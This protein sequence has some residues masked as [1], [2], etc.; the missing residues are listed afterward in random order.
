MKNRILRAAGLAAA[1]AGLLA[2]L[3]GTANA[4]ITPTLGSER[5]TVNGLPSTVSRG[6]TVNLVIWY[7]ET[8][9]YNLLSLAD[10]LALEAAGHRNPT[11]PYKGVS[12]SMQDPRDGRWTSA[13]FV[14]YGGYQLALGTGVKTT[15][16]YWAHVNVRISFTS[17][18]YTGSWQLT[19]SPAQ[20]YELL[21]AKNQN[22]VGYLNET[23]PN[24]TF[25]VK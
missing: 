24:Y 15:P 9:K 1:A 5:A 2:V 12:V 3:P 16:G 13:P 23:W 10:G 7:Q 19:P 18:A 4:A 11:T 22:V 8:S 21:N 14:I 6:T 20:A 25:K 17:A